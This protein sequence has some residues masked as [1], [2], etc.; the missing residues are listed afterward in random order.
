MGER[1]RVYCETTFWSWLVAKPS[2]NPDHA[3]KQ[4]YTRKWW[5]EC[6][7]FCDIYVS[8][9]VAREAADGDTVQASLRMTEIGKYEHLDGDHPQVY[10]LAMDLLRMHAVPEREIADAFH[11]ATA[12]V[13]GMDIL[14]TWNCRHMANLVTLPKTASV[15]ALAG[16]EC[17]RI[18]TPEKALEV[19]YV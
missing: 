14:L 3:V 7:P 5:D 9:H 18:L 11:I 8:N 19:Q 13:Y 6:A 1:L 17:P 10:S 2:T 4:A 12:A 16:Y 15:I